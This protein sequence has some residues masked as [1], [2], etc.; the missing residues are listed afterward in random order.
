M[1]KSV[2]LKEDQQ[3]AIAL[4]RKMEYWLTRNS[5]VVNQQSKSKKS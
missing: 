3:L 1:I 5:V 2:R 4:R